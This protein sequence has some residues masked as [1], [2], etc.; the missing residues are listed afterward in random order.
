[1]GCIYN[2][3]ADADALLSMRSRSSFLLPDI[4]PETTMEIGLVVCIFDIR[5]DS[6]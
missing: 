3:N 4:V 1:M 6:L 2:G 5:L